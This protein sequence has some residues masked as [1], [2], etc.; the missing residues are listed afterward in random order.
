MNRLITSTYNEQKYRTIGMRP[1]DVT[2][3]NADKLL[4]TVYKRVKIA[5][6]AQLK[7]SDSICVSIINLRQSLRK[8]ICQIGQQ[9]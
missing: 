6:L 9:R 7:V 2:P 8:V 4:I 5:A 3:A 1:I